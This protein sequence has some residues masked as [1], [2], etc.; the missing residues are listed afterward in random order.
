MLDVFVSLYV[1]DLT[2][3]STS[4]PTLLTDGLCCCQRRRYLQP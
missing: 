4:F 2:F 3:L 1:H